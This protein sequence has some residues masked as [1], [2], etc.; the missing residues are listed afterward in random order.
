MKTKLFSL[1]F[2]L[3]LSTGT[4]IADDGNGLPI[5]I[6]PFGNPPKD[7]HRSFT[8]VTVYGVF[9]TISQTLTLTVNTDD[10]VE[11]VIIYKDGVLIFD[12]V[13]PV[14]TDYDLS[15][16]GNGTYSVEVVLESGNTYIG[17]FTVN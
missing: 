2:A 10:S 16:Y 6:E 13:A 3:F 9:N 4:C 12:D 17:L 15:T 1:V 7:P 8:E 5:G 14:V 11:E